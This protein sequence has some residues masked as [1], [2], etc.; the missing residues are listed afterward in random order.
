MVNKREERR[1][2][3]YYQGG[4]IQRSSLTLVIVSNNFIRRGSPL[5]SSTEDFD[6]YSETY[7]IRAIALALDLKD[8]RS[9]K[10]KRVPKLTEGT[11]Y[12]LGNKT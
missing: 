11:K 9:R 5:K 8:K 1:S 4:L 2:I 12:S 10:R 7:C 3:A 6:Y